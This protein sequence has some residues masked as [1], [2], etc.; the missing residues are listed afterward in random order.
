MN[1]VCKCRMCGEVVDLVYKNV[2]DY[3]YKR[4]IRRKGGHIVCTHYFC[5]YSCIRL[6]DRVKKE[7]LYDGLFRQGDEKCE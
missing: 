2:K 1:I 5:S 6:Y 3:C 7:H 4:V